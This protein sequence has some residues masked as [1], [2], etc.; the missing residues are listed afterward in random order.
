MRRLQARQRVVEWTMDMDDASL[1][2]VAY[3]CFLFFLFLFVLAGDDDD[4]VRKCFMW[5]VFRKEIY[6]LR[7]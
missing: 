7:A 2:N 6:P 4:D 3:A 1:C 5:Q